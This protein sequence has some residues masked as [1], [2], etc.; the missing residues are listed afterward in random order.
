M[1]RVGG[2]GLPPKPVDEAS[3]AP[4]ES[5]SVDVRNDGGAGKSREAATPEKATPAAVDSFEHAAS[6]LERKLQA[7]SSKVIA[8]QIKFTSEH[9]AELAAAFA[10]IVRRHPK[11]GRKERARLFA[12]GILKHKRIGKLF[13]QASE[14]ELEEMCDTIA[15]QLDGSPVF[16]QLVE[17]VTEGARK[18]TLG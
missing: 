11:A 1:T 13:E 12:R 7:I 15:A 10:A 4:I 18:I 17:N 9:F 16:A 3:Q 5:R 14:D 2:G 8:G 6:Q